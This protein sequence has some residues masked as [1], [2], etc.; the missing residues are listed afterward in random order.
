MEKRINGRLVTV[1]VP[2]KNNHYLGRIDGLIRT[3]KEKMGKG[4]KA[5][6]NEVIREKEIEK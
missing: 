6:E 5:E 4:T 1:L 3:P 2:P